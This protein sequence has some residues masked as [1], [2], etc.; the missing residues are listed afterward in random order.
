MKRGN[1]EIGIERSASARN[2]HAPVASSIP[3]RTAAPLPACGRTDELYSRIRA[4]RVID[5]RGRPVSAA[6]VHDQHFCVDAKA[7]DL[8]RD[9]RKGVSAPCGFVERGNNNREESDLHRGAER[10]I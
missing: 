5:D 1:S 4:R 8:G 9:L 6:V 2:L 3:R 7:I 10:T